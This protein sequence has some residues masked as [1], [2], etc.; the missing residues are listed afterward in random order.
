MERLTAMEAMAHPYFY[1][2]REAEKKMSSS[3]HSNDDI[4]FHNPVDSH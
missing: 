4:I 2:V 3:E 1:P